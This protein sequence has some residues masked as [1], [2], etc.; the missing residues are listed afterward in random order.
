MSCLTVLTI[1][2]LKKSK[3]TSQ[4]I[5]KILLLDLPN[6]VFYL[7]EVK[8]AVASKL[9]KNLSPCGDWCKWQGYEPSDRDVTLKRLVFVKNFP[10]FCRP[11]FRLGVQR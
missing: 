3:L 9:S 2:I 5:L 7:R 6:V 8:R 4:S 1:K 11:V 10:A